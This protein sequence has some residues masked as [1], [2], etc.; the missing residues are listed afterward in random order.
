MSSTDG[1]LASFPAHFVCGGRCEGQEDFGEGGCIPA[2]TNTAD[3]MLHESTILR[4][5]LCVV[6]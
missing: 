1:C 4:L 2:A 3:R 5:A 6:M